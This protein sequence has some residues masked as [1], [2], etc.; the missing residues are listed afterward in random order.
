M[1]TGCSVQ[2]EDNIRLSRVRSK[3]RPTVLKKTEKSLRFAE[4]GT[5]IAQPSSHS[6]VTVL[7][8]LTGLRENTV[9]V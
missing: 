2:L 1:N 8:A 6:L 5:A 7:T 4:N 9:T 3:I